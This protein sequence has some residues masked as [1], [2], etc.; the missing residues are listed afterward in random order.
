MAQKVTVTLVDDLDGGTAEETVEFGIDGV[1]YEIDLSAGNASKLRGV[2]GPHVTAGRA[3]KK[4]GP[5][6]RGPVSRGPAAPVDRAQNKA[7][8]FWLKQNGHYVNERGRIPLS[9]VEAWTKAH[10]TVGG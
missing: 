3:R 7:I 5:A 8:R 4:R 1:T 9:G 2:L 10:A 6:S